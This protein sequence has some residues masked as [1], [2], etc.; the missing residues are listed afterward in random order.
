MTF[1]NIDAAAAHAATL[2]D[3]DA[4][5]A[6]MIA[7]CE[8]TDGGAWGQEFASGLEANGDKSWSELSHIERKGELIESAACEVENDIRHDL[9]WPL[10]A[11]LP[12]D[13]ARRAGYVLS[14][15]RA[16]YPK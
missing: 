16:L 11:G 3:I 7:F 2:D 1:Q 5:L 13:I 4:A 6:V 14:A 10:D 12:G 15:A 9:D 8:M